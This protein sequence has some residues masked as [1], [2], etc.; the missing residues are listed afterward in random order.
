M[1]ASEM[2]KISD[3]TVSTRGRY[4]SERDMEEFQD[5]LQF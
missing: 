5:S 1:L 3:T 4:F 2:T